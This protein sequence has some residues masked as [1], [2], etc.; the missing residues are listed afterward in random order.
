MHRVVAEPC[1]MPRHAEQLL[2]RSALRGCTCNTTGRLSDLRFASTQYRWRQI[3]ILGASPCTTASAQGC[4]LSALPQARAPCH[5]SAQND[6]HSSGEHTLPSAGRGA[7]GTCDAPSRGPAGCRLPLRQ[8]ERSAIA[9]HSIDGGRSILGA[10]PCT[11]ASAQ[12]CRLSA[13]PQAR[14]PCHSSAQNDQHSSGEHTLRISRPRRQ[15]YLRCAVPRAGGRRLPLR[16]V[17][18]GRA[19]RRA[20]G[21]RAPAAPASV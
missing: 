19:S 21:G 6:Q 9:L 12:G 11:T 18:A 14:A 10:S 3:G 1:R 7:S 20:R 4:R 8:A 17:E 16:Q 5:S 13:L 2:W 15:R